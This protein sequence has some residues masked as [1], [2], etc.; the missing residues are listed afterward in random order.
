MI[1]D[2]LLALVVGAQIG[3]AGGCAGTTRNAGVT[4]MGAA[5]APGPAPTVANREVH[6]TILQL[7][8]LYEITPTAGGRLG[9]PARVATI[10]KQ[11]VAA[12]P[13][14]FTVLA[15]DLLSPSALG[16]ARVDGQRLDGRQMV[17]V[18]NA[19]GLDFA[20]F[21][22]HEFDLSEASLKSRLTES[23]FHWISSNV[24]GANGVA[25]PNVEHH[26]I[27]RVAQGADTL[28]L[29][30]IGSTMERDQR[31]Y[32]LA[33]N[34]IESAIR[35]TGIV[36]DSADVI[37]AITHL[38][39]ARDIEIAETDP[40][41]DLILGGH[42]HENALYR[43]GE[44]L[45]PIA[46]ADAN[47]RSVWVHELWWDALN[48]HLRIESRLLSVTDSIAADPATESVVDEWVNR[49][50]AG[51]RGAGFEPD[52]LVATSTVPLDGMESSIFTDT[53]TLANLI[54]ESMLAETPGADAA[55]FNAG[56]IR[57]DDVLPPGPLREYDVIRTLPFGG[58]IL[59][60]EIDGAL[61]RRALEQGL[62]NR[63]TGGY[64]QYANITN[65]GD[66]WQ[67]GGQRLD[68]ARTYRVAVSDYLVSGR[69][70]G[71]GWLNREAPGLRVIREA[72][73]IRFA[74]MDGLKRRFSR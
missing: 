61:L 44:N 46:K 66:D 57:I 8:D 25:L 29:A 34:A 27:V 37:V 7:N 38:P 42:E 67:V 56:S 58:P 53:T 74:F 23:R 30:F 68:D 28:R 35:E 62:V 43:R 3:L 41:I 16:T 50:Y 24:T 17:A 22:N 9:G 69:E 39:I 47:S 4:P 63:G 26:E 19:M 10:R 15:G 59:E 40:A 11:L 13:H 71:L 18:L 20:T 5:S 33:S 36:R 31:P 2:G 64:L 55:M 32:A 49:A 54:A 14:T 1:R 12:N 65:S 48:H 52:R 51:F 70:Q 21:G 45:T 72:R 73:D 6:V 60:I